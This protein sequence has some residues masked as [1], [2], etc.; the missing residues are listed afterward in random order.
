MNNKIASI[1]VLAVLVLAPSWLVSHRW[2]HPAPWLFLAALSVVIWTDPP[3]PNLQTLWRDPADGRSG[4]F[5]GLN[6]LLM[7]FGPPLEFAL[8]TE[9]RPQAW[10]SW[11]LLGA[12]LLASGVLLR[13]WS[14]RTLGRFFTS[15][16]T[17]QAGH[18]VVELGP[19]QR[20]RHPA[21]GGSVIAGVG[22]AALFNSWIALVGTLLLVAVY[23]NR[24]RFEE[25]YLLQKLGTPYDQYCARTWRLVPFLY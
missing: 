14:I 6:M 2:A 22:T 7:M 8:R 9:L 12:I 17:V 21:Y 1:L 10:S 11:I 16:V 5:I 25:A 24:V 19:Y 3:A 18:E 13:V 20:I 4:V 23:L 15:S